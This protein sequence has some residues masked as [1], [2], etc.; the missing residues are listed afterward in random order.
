M[1]TVLVLPRHAQAV[2]PAVVARLQAL[3]LA[4]SGRLVLWFPVFLGTGALIYFGLRVE[5]P[6][7]AGAALALPAGLA[8]W[9]AR[10]WGRTVLLLLAAL[11]TGF[12]LSQFATLRALPQETLPFRAVVLT[13]RVAGVEVLPD[14]RR[15]TVAGAHLDN[16]MTLQ[17]RIRVPPANPLPAFQPGCKGCGKASRGGWRRGYP[18]RTERLPPR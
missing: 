4:E 18:T 6:P 14:G 1:P 7:W 17:R 16:G 3:A 9:L 8:A 2:T 13:G 5:P 10:G 11:A 12:A 15:V